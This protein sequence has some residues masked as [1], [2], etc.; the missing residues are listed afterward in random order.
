MK[1][2]IQTN[3]PPTKLLLRQEFEE[4]METLQIPEDM[5]MRGCPRALWLGTVSG[6]DA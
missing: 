3:L 6:K 2:A 5:G 4:V 1:T